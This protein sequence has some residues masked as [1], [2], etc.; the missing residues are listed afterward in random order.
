M[1]RGWESKA[2]ESQ[3]DAAAERQE[4]SKAVQLSAEQVARQR[5]RESIE[6]SRTRVL[7]DIATAGNPKYRA[8]LE[9]SL[10]FLDEKLKSLE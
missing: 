7:Q 6:L 2:V 4:R 9:R 1:A 5:E 10:Q 8:L 3:I